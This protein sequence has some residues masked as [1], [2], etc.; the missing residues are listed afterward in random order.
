MEG[1]MN[2]LLLGVGL[3][4]RI[5]PVGEKGSFSDALLI[6]DPDGFHGVDF[7]IKSPDISFFPYFPHKEP[8][9]DKPYVESNGVLYGF[10]IPSLECLIRM[11]P[12]LVCS[13]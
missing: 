7:T 1:D 4:I 12:H 3:K 5:F 6:L 2:F 9:E 11:A 8:W 13:S 10:I